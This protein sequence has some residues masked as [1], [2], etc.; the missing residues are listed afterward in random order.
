MQEVSVFPPEVLVIITSYITFVV[1]H[2]PQY[3]D[4]AVLSPRPGPAAPVTRHYPVT[5]LQ[6]VSLTTDPCDGKKY[7]NILVFSS[8]LMECVII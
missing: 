4:A 3:C 5:Q 2:H 6:S 8:C 7:V 1:T